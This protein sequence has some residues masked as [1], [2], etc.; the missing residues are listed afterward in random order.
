M[1]PTNFYISVVIP[2]FNRPHTLKRAVASVLKQTYTPEE[3]WIIDDGST[4]D[5]TRLIASFQEKYPPLY[6]L[7]TTRKGVSHARNVGIQRSQA[8][9]VAFLDS[10]DEWRPEKLER[11]VDLLSKRPDLKIIHGEEIWIR[12]GRRVNPKQKHQKSGGWIFERCLPLCMISPSAVMIHQTVFDEIGRFDE[13]LPVCEDYDLWLR[14][15][16]K[17][18]IGFIEEPIIFKFGGHDD[19]LSRKYV[20]MDYWRIIAMHRL[21]EQQK[22]SPAQKKTLAKELCRKAEILLAGYQ[23]HDNLSDHDEI[24]AIYQ[25]WQAMIA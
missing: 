25:Q 6:G 11:Q 20:A 9:W 23:K 15:S 4:D 24:E 8:P 13:T 3:I 22:F 10:D 17:Y 7:K 14:I 5:T 19:Q 2:T 16:L 12:K 18:E 1:S 21:A